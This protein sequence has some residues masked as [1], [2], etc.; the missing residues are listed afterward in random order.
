MPP[1]VGTARRCGIGRGSEPRSDLRRIPTGRRG[2]PSGH[3]V[4]APVIPPPDHGRRG[5]GGRVLAATLAGAR[6]GHRP[7]GGRPSSARRARRAAHR[8]DDAPAGGAAAPPAHRRHRHRRLRR[9]RR[10]QRLPARDRAVRGALRALL[11]RLHHLARQHP[12]G[13]DPG[14]HR[15]RRRLRRGSRPGSRVQRGRQ[16][17]GGRVHAA[18]RSTSS[19]SAGPE[20]ALAERNRELEEL[21]EAQTRSAIVEER[22]RIAREVHDVVGHSLV[23]ITLQAR[24]G[25]RRLRA[26]QSAPARPSARSRPSPRAR[27]RR[28]ARPSRRSA[29][30]PT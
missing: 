20:R 3:A 25:L 24:A 13:R 7:D 23:A 26:A 21:R 9:R 17:P 28:P 16:P 10:R 18:R 22:M 30:A 12:A 2:L 8:G 5:R 15:A 14:W 4:R 6:R 1:T 27:S 11:A 19:G 29:V